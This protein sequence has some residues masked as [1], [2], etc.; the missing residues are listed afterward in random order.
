MARGNQSQPPPQ[1]SSSNAVG[2][3]VL[4]EDSSSQYYLQN[5]DHPGLVLVSHLL[6]DSLLYMSAAYEI[7]KDLRDRFHQSNAPRIFQLK[8]RLN[9]LQQGSM[10]ISSYYTR[11]RT[12]WDELKDFQPISV[13]NC[14]SMKE[15]L[16]Y[17]NQEC[18]MQ[19]LMGLNESY[20]QIRAQILMMEPFPIISK[21]FSLVIQEER[22][23]SIH[24]DTPASSY[25]QSLAMAAVR[26]TSN[27]KGYKSDRPVCSH[28]NFPYHT[29]DKCYKLHGYPPSHPRYKQKQSE[30]KAQD[31]QTRITSDTQVPKA[32]E[33]LSQ[34]HCRQLI[35]FL[36]SQIQLGHDNTSVSQQ[37][38]N[39]SAPCF[40]GTLHSTPIIS[41]S[42]I[43]DTGATHHI[44]CALGLFCTLK[45]FISNVTL[46]NGSMVP[47]THIGSVKLS[48]DLTL[49]NVLYV[50]HFKF[51]LLSISSL[52]KQISCSVTF[53]SDS[54]QI[55]VLNQSKM[56]G[57]GK[58]MGDLYIFSPLPVLST[59]CN[60]SSSKSSLWHYRMGHASFPQLSVLGK[61]LGTDFIHNNVSLDCTVC[62]LSKQKRLPFN[63]NNSLSKYSFDLI[64]IDIWGP[65]N[66]LSVDGFNVLPT[67]KLPSQPLHTPLPTSSIDV[68]A[69]PHRFTS[70]PFH[71]NDY[72]CY[73]TTSHSSST[74]HPLSI[75]LGTH[76]LSSSYRAFVHNISS[77]VEPHSFSQA[78]VQPE[79]RQ[80]MDAE[81]QALESNK[82]W[83]IVS[84]PPNKRAVGC[85]WVYKAKFRA[86]GTLERYK[87]RLVAK[88]YTQQEGIDYF[89]TFS[90]VAKIVT[91]RT[92]LA[93]A[94]VHGWFLTQLDVNNAFLHG[95]LAEEVYMLLP[96]GYHSK[97]VILPTN[98]VCKLHK[99]LYGLKQASR[100]WFSKFSSTLL[101]IG[102]IQSHA[103][104]SLFIRS[105]G[106]VF[107]ALL[108]YVDDIVIATNDEKEAVDLKIFLDSHF[109]LKD[110]GNLKYFLGIEVA[111]S[112]RGISICQRHYALQLLT[113]AGLLGCKSRSTPLDTNLKLN[114]EDGDLLTDPFLY[115]KLMGKLLYLTITR[116]DL[117]YSVNKLSQYVSK[118]RGPHLQ[119]VYS[120]LKYVKG[121][122]G[123]GLFYSASTT[124]K[125]SFFSDSDWASCQ[126]TRRSVS[127][128]CVL[129]GKSLISWKSK[130]Q[131]TVSRSSAEAEYRSTANATC[132]VIWLR[133]LLTDFQVPCDE[134]AVLFCDNQS[135]IHIASNPV[136]HERTKHI[137]IDCHIVREKLQC[138][139]IKILY[140]STVLQLADLFT[141]SLLPSR[142]RMLLSK[143]GINNIHAP[144]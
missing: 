69:R 79:W 77:I 38:S 7:W 59:V 4:F 48:S 13:C 8:K 97:G 86:D 67:Q 27:F 80:A 89:E 106:N 109:K 75:V 66:P 128:Y 92:L 119:A 72:H 3:K 108:V 126:D 50:P 82:T 64:H 65:F 51:N 122:V 49:E 15:W 137:E 29:V 6:T 123:Q 46:P 71:L 25:D 139:L 124:L 113:E 138:G 47:S 95:E 91:V 85:R 114:D 21:T 10:D 118:P 45:F 140:L 84:L 134:P 141:K 98:A 90:P 44:C 55:Q 110:L 23:R 132:E 30:G 24:H 144:S 125:L 133:S 62:L 112:S 121:S 78:V 96:P 111:R 33:V 34:D 2:N 63:S 130:K 120:V 83:S 99:S 127:G 61:T 31:H 73:T 41:S 143:M 52:T 117:A 135:A 1:G 19:F 87:A 70:K 107:L 42:W 74:S 32:G 58:R 57:M 103:D 102:F 53:L 39:T 131:Q 16:N 28:C 17:H 81:L 68:D 60:V 14:G 5:G 20:A 37:Q 43:I 136:F 116:P 36:S 104:S 142:F 35:A 56:I 115:R 76:K 9:E 94:A 88:G 26:G 11:M 100:Q 40:T 129:L 105:Q 101:T 18:V 54:C 93:L 22:Q 12:L